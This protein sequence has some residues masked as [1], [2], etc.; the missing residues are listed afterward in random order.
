MC[1]SVWLM[2]VSSHLSDT[3]IFCN[4]LG[5]YKKDELLEAARWVP[6]LACSLFCFF[7][8]FFSNLLSTLWNPYNPVF[9]PLFT[10][11]LC[12]PSFVSFVFCHTFI[13]VYIYFWF[14]LCFI[15][16][17]SFINLFSSPPVLNY[18]IFSSPGMNTHFN[19]LSFHTSLVFQFFESSALLSQRYLHIFEFFLLPCIIGCRQL[20]WAVC[21]CFPCFCMW[22]WNSSLFLGVC[23]WLSAR[24]LSRPP[25]FFCLAHTDTQIHTLGSSWFSIGAPQSIM[26]SVGC[27]FCVCRL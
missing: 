22:K 14:Y 26:G 8:L 19:I 20:M 24:C 4:H 25:P 13:L 27:F 5:E 21:S 9:S 6:D 3:M 2:C 18:Y 10:L 7:L 16:L 17:I 1:V 23:G 11:I 12:C 15:N